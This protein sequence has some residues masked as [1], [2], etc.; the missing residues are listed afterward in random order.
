MARDE[1]TLA[2]QWPRRLPHELDD[3][4]EQESLAEYPQG[5]ED[6]APPTSAKA[7]LP[8]HAFLGSSLARKGTLR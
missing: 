3:L 8:I 1:A 5:D 6:G 2:D 4:L 7:S